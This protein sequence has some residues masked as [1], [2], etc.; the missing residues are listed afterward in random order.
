V[1]RGLEIIHHA[2]V[3][4]DD[5]V[6]DHAESVEPARSPRRRGGQ[7]LVHEFSE[8]RDPFAEVVLDLRRL[9][10]RVTGADNLADKCI[11]PVGLR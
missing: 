2:Q 10:A 4:R 7:A 5:A 3:A 11:E 8:L 9:R 6:E 1:R